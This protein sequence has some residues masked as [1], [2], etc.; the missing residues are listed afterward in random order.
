M[1]EG[2]QKLVE[3]YQ[4]SEKRVDKSTVRI[5]ILM[6][7]MIGIVV[8]MKAIQKTASLQL[9]FIATSAVLVLLS[10]HFWGFYPRRALFADSSN[11]I[12]RGVKI[13]QDNPFLKV[14]F[15][16]D[17]LKKFSALGQI[18][19]MAIF[20]LFL[21]YFFSVSY[22][23]LAKSINPDIIAKLRP[24]TP[25]STSLISLSLGYAYYKAIKPLIHLK[26]SI[27]GMGNA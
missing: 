26:R 7:F 11:I 12:L 24:I 6:V 27:P 25:I 5:I 3:E 13:E 19:R 2:H 18:I 16:K 21:I 10:W 8:T 9:N 4:A 22:T 17:H 15:F 20:D 23:Q 1:L 14:S